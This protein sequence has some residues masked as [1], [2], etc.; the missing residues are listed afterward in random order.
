MH[1]SSRPP[2]A[3]FERGIAPRYVVTGKENRGRQLQR[4]RGDEAGQQ[5]EET[6]RGAGPPKPVRPRTVTNPIAPDISCV[7]P[8]AL[9]PRGPS[10]SST[11]SRSVPIT[12]PRPIVRQPLATLDGP[13]ASSSARQPPRPQPPAAPIAP[14]SS[15]STS[16][17]A[18]AAS[19]TSISGTSSNI[20]APASAPSA[21]SVVADQVA[22]QWREKTDSRVSELSMEHRATRVLLGRLVQ[23][24]KEATKQ[25]K[26][27]WKQRI[28]LRTS[29][30]YHYLHLCFTRFRQCLL[31]H[32]SGV[33]ALQA[34]RED[35]NG[36][37]QD[38]RRR[39]LWSRVVK[40]WKQHY[41]ES[42]LR[43][44]HNDRAVE[45]RDRRLL[46]DAFRT[47]V[48]RR[49]AIQRAA[50]V[51]A[52]VS[53]AH[54]H[55]VL[56]LHYT[57][58]RS[59]CATSALSR[60]QLQI[61]RRHARRA[62][63]RRLVRRWSREVGGRREKERRGQKFEAS[64]KKARQHDLLLSWHRLAQRQI[65]LARLLQ[66][67]LE[68]RIVQ[69]KKL[70]WVE[71]K[72]YLRFHRQ[73]TRMHAV[74]VKHYSHVRQ[75][76]A[77][78]RWRKRVQLWRVQRMMGAAAY[79][80]LEH[81]FTTWRRALASLRASRRLLLQA[82][83]HAAWRSMARAVRE[84][85]ECARG[86][87]ERRERTEKAIRMG[88]KKRLQLAIFTWRQ[89]AAASARE[90]R[91]E[92]TAQQYRSIK[93]RKAVVERLRSMVIT[94][95]VKAAHHRT[96]LLHSRSRAFS[97]W[98]SFA[99]S[100]RSAEEN[101]R[102]ASRWSYLRRLAT[103]FRRWR[104]ERRRERGVEARLLLR[105]TPILQR[106]QREL[107]RAWSVLARSVRGERKRMELA[108]RVDGQTLKLQAFALWLSLHR[109]RV[110]ARTSSSR[111]VRHHRLRVLATMF[112]AW[113]AVAYA[114]RD[115]RSRVQEGV[116]WIRARLDAEQR[117]RIFHRWQ[118]RRLERDTF[119]QRWEQAELHHAR[120]LVLRSYRKMQLVFEERQKQ[121]ASLVA[122]ARRV[123]SRLLR[124]CLSLWS[125]ALHLRHIALSKHL[126]ALTF[127]SRRVQ[128]LAWRG[129]I[130]YHRV[131]QWKRARLQE[132]LDQR[133]EKLRR[134]TVRMWVEKGTELAETALVIAHRAA[135]AAFVSLAHR[136]LALKYA[137]LWR[138]HVRRR[139]KS[140]AKLGDL[141]RRRVEMRQ[142]T[143]VGEGKANGS[144]MA[145]YVRAPP[146]PLPDLTPQRKTLER[147]EE[148][149]YPPQ[150]ATG[151]SSQK[152]AEPEPSSLFS[153]PT[154]S[155]PLFPIL[156]SHRPPPRRPAELLLEF[157]IHLPLPS[158]TAGRALPAMGQVPGSAT[159]AQPARNHLPVVSAP[160]PPLMT[161]PDDDPTSPL[162][163]KLAALEDHLSRLLAW[164][165][166][167]KERRKRLQHLIDMQQHSGYVSSPQ[168]SHEIAQ[169]QQ[170][171]AADV[172]HRPYFA[173]QLL[174]VQNQITAM[175]I[176]GQA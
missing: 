103:V 14:L 71:W 164:K 35:L 137:L 27:E 174:T 10:Q 82:A 16:V 149:K 84:W 53:R 32:S 126:K 163:R 48:H 47:W 119:R 107:L 151:P 21:S 23:R 26:K 22:R 102:K 30:R 125:H 173:E 120:G 81:T 150:E 64:V 45:S 75:H 93:M 54:T 5:E 28:S 62:E 42:V 74:A 3:V 136:R 124:A 11:S 89:N 168:Q 59:S 114:Q 121:K 143:G 68:A 128:Q 40:R 131:K 87:R 141:F 165:T 6:K 122:L 7:A 50:S 1:P 175:M 80:C 24:W 44:D 18:A 123:E 94:A 13:A 51:G 56:R 111:S 57:S 146:L 115:V 66:R 36:R 76:D 95:H 170:A 38:W 130:R 156:P 43:A 155:A 92:Y 55:S 158:I 52:A 108:V 104:E 166:E 99:L 171:V 152:R 176:N 25:S 117:R 135:P 134:E 159:T 147:E 142:W 69:A 15:A 34:R 169:L 90:L 148:Q 110:H 33:K 132:A 85:R 67:R 86:G 161:S 144:A 19:S 98:S 20:A 2:A 37:A 46:T 154:N 97:L 138:Y 58:W 133:R 61:A 63:L 129:W 88:N 31:S 79:T 41:T 167:A 73:Y 12:P 172:E 39:R 145:S 70:V 4:Q 17:H 157:P 112:R 100:R 83:G 9:S 8:S 72:I 162:H 140:D 49:R 116:R 77:V 96:L 65:L 113:D 60:A 153:E 160:V 139:R 109:A 106:R 118:Q 91:L 105:A 127:W 101:R 29:A 78:E